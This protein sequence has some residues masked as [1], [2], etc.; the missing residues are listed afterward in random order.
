MPDREKVIEGLN[1]IHAVA[2]GLGDDECYLNSIGIKQLQT[3]INDAT[4]LLRV[5]DPK[6]L[7][8]E[9][10]EDT[11]GDRAVW[12]EAFL[13]ESPCLAIICSKSSVENAYT[14]FDF[15]FGQKHR[16]TEKTY[17][18]AWRCWDRKP[19]ATQREAVAWK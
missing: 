5:E 4:E 1:D 11:M 15:N 14:I 6:V 3:L 8:Y 9:E 10:L 18:K 13:T 19:S 2:C 17:G 16:L 7:S 12:Y